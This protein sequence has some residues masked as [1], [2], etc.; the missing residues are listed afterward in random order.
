[1]ISIKAR[2]GARG[3]RRVKSGCSTCKTRHKKCDELKPVCTPC[4]ESGWKCGFLDNTIPS[5]PTCTLR[6]ADSDT[7]HFEYFRLICA[8]E[9]SL[10]FEMHTWSGIVLHAAYTDQSFRRIALAVG[11]LSRSRYIKSGQHQPA[12]SYAL[13]QYNMAIR[14][15]SLLD[16]SPENVLRI[17]LACIT[18]IVLEFLL[19]NYSR[20]EIHMR[21]AV[22]MLSALQRGF[23]IQTIFY[24]QAITYIQDTMSVYY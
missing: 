13:R 4:R 15:L 6:L 11:A 16:H 12:E 23:D 14:E 20:V 5:S 3:I 10:F 2:R 8:P 19:E 1:M 22:S 17:V 24:L 18:L 9:F 7:M 21:S